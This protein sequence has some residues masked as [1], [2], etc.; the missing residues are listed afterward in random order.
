[1]S[2]QGSIIPTGRQD[3]D[4]DLGRLEAELILM[5]GLVEQAIFNALN[6]LKNRDIERSQKVI[7]EDDHIDETELEIERSCVEL[8]RRE[9]PMAS[10]LRRIIASLHI[11]G[12][13]E[14]IG[15]YAEGI[16]KI[17]I[18]MGSQPPLKE[19]IDIP[20]M[21]DMAVSMLKR[22][23]EAFISR[24]PETVRNLS[25]ELENDDDEVD[26]LYAKV[27][28]DL[29]ELVKRNTDNVERATYLMWVAHNVERVADR[30]M[31]IVERAL[32]Q[33]TGELVSGT[34]QID[35]VPE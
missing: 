24:D 27:Q 25:V 9:A 17:S 1:M 20:R 31:N 18:T 10:D 28:G 32:Y 34:T 26:D 13:L 35:T 22:S 19:L 5:S 11:A 6:A 29:M 16:A 15:D 23:L 4:R 30:A 3:F 12:E 21:G 8:I 2:E 14:R 33:A 7:D